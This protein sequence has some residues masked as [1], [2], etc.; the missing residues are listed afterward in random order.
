MLHSKV[1]QLR[2]RQQEDVHVAETE[3]P[4]RIF[5]KIVNYRNIFTDLST[6]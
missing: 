4:E 6:K 5:G 2:D 1:R 3:N